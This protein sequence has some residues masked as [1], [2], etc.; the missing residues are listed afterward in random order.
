MKITLVIFSNKNTPK[1]LK[2]SKIGI[3]MKKPSTNYLWKAFRLYLKKII[4]KKVV[5]QVPKQPQKSVSKG[6]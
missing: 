2:T 5:V 6:Y 1:S 4:F 3:K